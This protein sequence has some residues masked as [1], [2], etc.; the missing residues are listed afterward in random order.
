MTGYKD[1]EVAVQMAGE[2][3]PEKRVLLVIDPQ[4]DIIVLAFY[5]EALTALEYAEKRVI[6]TTADMKLAS[7]DL[8]LI[9]RLKKSMESRRKD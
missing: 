8:N 3:L 6:K 9:R 4:S 7:D 5:T 1:P 2:L